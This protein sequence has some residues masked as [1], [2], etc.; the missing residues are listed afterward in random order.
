MLTEATRLGLALGPA[1]ARAGP[2]NNDNISCLY[3]S[4][5]F[6]P[7]AVSNQIHISMHYLL[8]V[9]IS[10]QAGGRPVLEVSTW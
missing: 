8:S 2:A 5:G 3:F 10:G 7:N 6:K 9:F 4:C 1:P